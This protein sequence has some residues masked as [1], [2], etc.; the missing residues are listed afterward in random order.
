MTVWTP[1]AGSTNAVTDVSGVW[2][3]TV[4]NV[5]PQRY[6]RSTAIVPCP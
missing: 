3:F 6:C 5:A 1:V 2:Q 4:T